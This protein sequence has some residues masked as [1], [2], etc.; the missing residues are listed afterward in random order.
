MKDNQPIKPDPKWDDLEGP[1]PCLT[2]TYRYGSVA[3][4]IQDF[5]FYTLVN[6][7]T[8]KAPLTTLTSIIGAAVQKAKAEKWTDK[9]FEA[10][11]VGEVFMNPDIP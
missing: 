9:E 7:H 2:L 5:D 11:V 10:H 1:Y 6:G 3:F 4:M 8:V